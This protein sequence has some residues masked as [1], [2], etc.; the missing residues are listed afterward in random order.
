MKVNKLVFAGAA[1]AMA[2]AGCAG[3]S[4]KHGEAVDLDHQESVAGETVRRD[5]I[6]DIAF[7]FGKHKIETTEIAR[8]FQGDSTEIYLSIRAF[9]LKEYPAIN[10]MIAHKADSV[11]AAATLDTIPIGQIASVPQ[12]I[13]VFDSMGRNFLDSI[14]PVMTRS[15]VPGFNISIDF[16]P[17]YAY[18]DLITYQTY[19]SSFLGGAHGDYDIYFTTFNPVT[20]EVF[21]FES[22]VKPDR[23]AE[24][25][26]ALVETIADDHDISVDEYLEQVNN[27]LIDRKSVV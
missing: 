13:D 24:V 6:D 27:Y 9:A 8:I 22:L 11:Y 25:R 17:A 21:T 20:A 14:A 18:K 1:M 4:I 19:V 16:R 7:D 10:N 3:R 15:I 2:L 12:L 23:Q 5:T 26:K